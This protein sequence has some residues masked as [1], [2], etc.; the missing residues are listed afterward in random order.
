M[1]NQTL[2]HIRQSRKA[3]KGFTL[4]EMVLYIGLVGLLMT[5]LTNFTIDVMKIREA[6]SRQ[7]LVVSNAKRVLDR[8]THEITQAT[9]ITL[10]SGNTIILESPDRGTTTIQLVSDAIHLTQTGRDENLH[11][12]RVQAT[13]FSVQNLTNGNAQNIK[14]RLTLEKNDYS[15]TFQTSV[16]RRH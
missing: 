11:D 2:H 3:K 12:S 13:A 6:S 15:K 14:I 9:S 5:G 10:A 16:E 7:S 1:I 8:I 4:I